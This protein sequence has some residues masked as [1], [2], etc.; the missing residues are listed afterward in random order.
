MNR[1]IRV[2][3]PILI[4]AS[5]LAAQPVGKTY[6]ISAD[7]LPAPNASRS[8]L[9]TPKLIEKPPNV[10]LQMPPGF[11]A[12]AFASGL[13]NPRWMSVAP[14]GD[15]FCVESRVERKVKEQPHR[16][17]VLRDEDG[18]GRAETR[19]VFTENLN[20]PF[21]IA[22]HGGYIYIANTGSVVRWPYKDGQTKAQGEPQIVIPN[23]PERGYN[24]HWTR[25]ILFSQ[26]GGKLYLTVGSKDNAAEEEKPRATIEEYSLDDDG[27]PDGEPRIYA[28]GMRNPVGLAFE[29]VTGKLW[30]NVN[31]R[32]YLGD[33]LVP[34][35][36]T[37]V[38][39]GGFYGWPYYYLGA[40]HDP[41]LPKKPELN[42]RIIVPDVLFQSHSAPLGLCFYQ[43]EQFPAEYSG[44]AFVAF[45][46]STNRKQR[47][48]YK[49]VRVRFDKTAKPTAATKIF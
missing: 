5:R 30:A 13:V 16:V 7:N 32:D 18:D 44:D 29:P 25:N 9:T 8:T 4:M 23:I 38:Q 17:T 12:E 22:F 37:G 48:G 31:E 39:D 2:A 28:S 10:K 36:L 49:I 40:H 27:M 34:D 47:T 45:H 15:V 11:H 42:D 43:G 24:Q 33:D 3:F 14:N 6:R 1:V 41:R 46:G 26:D 35:F 19:H 21:G 20:L